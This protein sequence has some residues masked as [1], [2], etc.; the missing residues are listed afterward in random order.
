MTTCVLMHGNAAQIFHWIQLNTG[1][2]RAVLLTV[3]DTASGGRWK[4][5]EGSLLAQWKAVKVYR[6]KRIRNMNLKII[7]TRFIHFVTQEIVDNYITSKYAM[8]K[9]YSTGD[10]LC[11]QVS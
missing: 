11:R 8:C 10:R 7:H 4:D 2:Y 5:S 3:D 1:P 6:R 9:L